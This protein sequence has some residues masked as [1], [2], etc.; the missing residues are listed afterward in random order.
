MFAAARLGAR[1]VAAP[2]P[3]PRLLPPTSLPP[4]P[5]AMS[6]NIQQQIR[7]NSRDLS[8]YLKDLNAFT[9]DVKAKDEALTRKEVR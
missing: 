5:A 6:L 9:S 1:R 7:D 3:P 2:P 4:P 8:A